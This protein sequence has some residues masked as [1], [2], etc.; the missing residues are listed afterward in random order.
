LHRSKD[1]L[2]AGPSLGERALLH[3][4]QEE[5]RAVARD[6]RKTMRNELSIDQALAQLAHLEERR[7][8]LVNAHAPRA[9]SMATT[10]GGG[11]PQLN[12]HDPF[13][14]ALERFELDEVESEI[15]HLRDHI[16]SLETG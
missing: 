10:V 5:L 2:I 4:R 13:A 1:R 11:T 14:G 7:A 12:L 3:S 15:R 6:L 8:R 9:H 16:A